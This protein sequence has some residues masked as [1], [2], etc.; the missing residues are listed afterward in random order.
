RVG[1]D[2]IAYALGYR[3]D[4]KAGVGRYIELV[5]GENGNKRDTI[6][7]S[8]P[9]NKSAQAYFRRDGSKGD[10]VTLIRE[11]LN[12]FPV[13][14][15][16]DW[17]KIAKVLA[18]FANMPEP[19]YREDSDYVKS[20][21]T[22]AI[23]D[24]NRYEVKPINPE[25]IPALFSQRGIS[26][27]TVKALSPFISLIR[28][29]R[30]EKFNGYNIGFPYTNGKDDAIKGYEIRGHGGYKSKAAGTDSSTSAWVADL[31]NGNN[32]MVKSVFFCES[33]FDAMAFY[34]MNKTQLGN[35]VA[36]VSLGGTFSDKQITNTMER[37]PYARAFDC[38]DNDLAGRIYGLRMMALLEGV[39]MKI[40]KKSDTLQIEAKG[41]SFELNTER[42]LL[43]QV[44]KHL[45]IRYKMGQWLPPKVFKDWNDCLMNKPME[46][47]H[48]PR[49]EE[50]E[51]NLTERRKAGLKM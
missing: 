14:G 34:Q 15:K 50:R 31:S 49:K 46:I 37:F 32:G 20:V 33:A 51:Q 35:D 40:N 22:D 21:K 27:E 16:D 3:L 36:L 12:A 42:P 18:R 5:L 1:V 30:N 23:F 19:E 24:S 28:D 43:A 26:D 9:N 48:S 38:F 11:N 10:V 7:V 45:S 2:D 25:R 6:I 17:Q 44:S 13:S 39:P 4:R 8:N 29:K 41:K 47:I